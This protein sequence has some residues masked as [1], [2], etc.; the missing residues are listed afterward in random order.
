MYAHS[1]VMFEAIGSGSYKVSMQVTRTKNEIKN[2]HIVVYSVHN[3]TW[4]D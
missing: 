1:I 3:H 2:L 4:V